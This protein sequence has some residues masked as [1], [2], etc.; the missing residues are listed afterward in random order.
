MTTDAHEFGHSVFDA[1]NGVGKGYH[2]EDEAA[3]LNEAFSD[4]FS[5]I[6]DFRTFPSHTLL[7]PENDYGDGSGLVDMIDPPLSH[8]GVFA[9]SYHDAYWVTTP[10][11]VPCTLKNDYCGVHFNGGP[12]EHWFAL[13]V[14]G[15]RNGKNFGVGV[16]TLGRPFNVFGLGLDDAEKIAFRTMRELGPQP[17]YMGARAA[18]LA[19]ASSLFP[20]LASGVDSPQYISV[21][22]AWSAVGVGPGY[23]AD[24]DETYG[25]GVKRIVDDADPWPYRSW[26]VA[27]Y[28][29]V[30]V[31][32]FTL[33][34]DSAFPPG[35]VVTAS[36][37]TDAKGNAYADFNLDTG[38][39]YYISALPTTGNSYCLVNATTQAFCD[40]MLQNAEASGI[41]IVTAGDNAFA[42]N[43]P[44]QGGASVYPWNTTFGWSAPPSPKANIPLA[45]P[46]KYLLQIAADSDVDFVHPFHTAVITASGSPSGETLTLPILTNKDQRWRV[47]AVGPND[48]IDNQPTFA[49]PKEDSNAFNTA[50]VATT[51]ASPATGTHVPPWGAPLA[52][53]WL[54]N[55]GAVSYDVCIG[56]NAMP[57]GTCSLPYSGV[58]ALVPNLDTAGCGALDNGKK[59]FW[60]VAPR[61]PALF[62]NEPA[63]IVD[64]SPRG[65][66]VV[67]YGLLK[68]PVLSTASPTYT[69]DTDPGATVGFTWNALPGADHHVIKVTKPNN[70]P[71]FSS[72]PIAGNKTSYNLFGVRN[73]LGSL[74]ATITA[75]GPAPDNIPIASAPVTYQ[76][77]LAKPV[78]HTPGPNLVYP[79]L[80]VPDDPISWTSVE[81]A[82]HYQLMIQ[83]P[84]GIVTAKA[85]AASAQLTVG[86]AVY[87]SDGTKPPTDKTGAA[88]YKVWVSAEGPVGSGVSVASAAVTYLIGPRNPMGL[89]GTLDAASAPA[90]NAP[91]VLHWTNETP[92]ATYRLQVRDITVSPWEDVLDQTNIGAASWNVNTFLKPARKYMWDV[93]ADLNGRKSS[94]SAMRYF[95]TGGSCVSAIG[96]TALSPLNFHGNHAGT[97][98]DPYVIGSTGNQIVFNGTLSLYAVPEAIDYRVGGAGTDGT[99]SF[100]NMTMTG[101]GFNV[102]QG[103]VAPEVEYYVFAQ[104]KDKYGCWTLP[105]QLSQF[106]YIKWTQ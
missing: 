32:D 22:D 90:L 97:R 64:P 6:L 23:G 60:T 94:W 40:W 85:V 11:G 45:Q 33:S 20:S 46:I 83:D 70:Q 56:D 16:N 29:Y 59:C 98:D 10:P 88:G 21:M 76:V 78:I 14:G 51:L 12:A 47:V 37:N 8:A 87:Q 66:L 2:P 17:T 79:Y 18:S 41:E 36:A 100:P 1:S 55:Q 102:V 77:T 106:Y 63:E 99:L 4:I 91:Y 92:G 81:G 69:Y 104:A 35:R 48:A 19:V 101:N 42:L 31:F 62:G 71:P 75:Y 72:P 26:I 9:S 27:K 7:E 103:Y 34:D 95:T 89:E 28:P 93:V 57:E 30:G 74:G 82:D 43:A 86:N 65:L 44:A 68:K 13:I 80:Y 54:G 5:T 38:Q 84:D 25:E 15:Q 67:D 39:T 96:Q 49:L 53:T 3:N 24:W 58:T 105:S 61:G 52:L 73:V 50:K